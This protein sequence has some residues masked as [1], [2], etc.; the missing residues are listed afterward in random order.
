MKRREFF[1]K[2]G[3]VAAVTAVIP[4]MSFAASD[5]KPVSPNKMDYNTAVKLIAGITAVTAAT[6]PTFLKKSLLCIV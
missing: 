6:V 5:A 3:T 2:V 4:A 1:K